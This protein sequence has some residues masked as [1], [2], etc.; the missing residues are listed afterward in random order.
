VLCYGPL[1]GD[2]QL[3]GPLPWQAVA[4]VF[5]ALSLRSRVFSP[6]DNSR[7]EQRNLVSAD[8]DA[9]LEA[10][11]TSGNYKTQELRAEVERRGLQVDRTMDKKVLLDVVGRYFEEREVGMNA[12]TDGEEEKRT[13]SW[14]PPGVVFPIM[15]VLV[16]APLRSLSASMV[17]AASTGRLN[18]AHLNDP[19]LLWLALHLCIGDTWNTINNVESRLG[20]AVPGVALVWLSTLFAARQFYDVQPQA[21]GLLALTAL[22]IS[23]AGALVADTWRLNNEVSEEPLYPYKRKGAISRTRLTFEPEP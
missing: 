5:F 4:G 7:P 19:V 13:P 15:W 22:W 12:A 11:L 20:A 9:A 18:E 3:G 10:M 1:P 17:Y 8:D 14:M 21:G 6:L 23:A 16:V 2:V